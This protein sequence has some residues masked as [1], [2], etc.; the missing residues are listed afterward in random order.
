MQE[1]AHRAV[2]AAREQDLVAR[3]GGSSRQA[4]SSMSQGS[5]F[6]ES[7]SSCRSAEPLRAITGL[8]ASRRGA[9]CAVPSSAMLATSAARRVRR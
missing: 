3:G 7:R 9:R 4:I 6:Q 2:V 5:V 8:G 1:A